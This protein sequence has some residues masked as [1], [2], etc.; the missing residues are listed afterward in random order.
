MPSCREPAAHRVQDLAVDWGL[1]QEV[2]ERL[3]VLDGGHRRD[4][5]RGGGFWG[6]RPGRFAACRACPGTAPARHRP[7]TAAQTTLARWPARWPPADPVALPAT[8]P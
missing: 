7:R 4:G 6:G 2:E 1:L 8:C 3:V 5:H